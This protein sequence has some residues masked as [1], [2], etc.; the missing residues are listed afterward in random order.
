MPPLALTHPAQAGPT[1]AP[2]SLDE[3]CE[4]VSAAISPNASGESHRGG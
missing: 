1:V 2:W 4:P 3:A